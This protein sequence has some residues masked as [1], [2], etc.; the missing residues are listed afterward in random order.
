MAGGHKNAKF[1]AMGAWVF[2]HLDRQSNSALLHD[3]DISPILLASNNEP[4]HD[5][6][7][8]GFVLGYYD[9]EH[10]KWR[11][12]NPNEPYTPTQWNHLFTA[13]WHNVNPDPARNDTK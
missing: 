13:A 6:G 2:P 9:R 12:R 1:S 11:V 3:R 10:D 4:P 8:N 7:I 5:M